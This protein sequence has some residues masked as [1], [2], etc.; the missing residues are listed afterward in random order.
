MNHLIG[1]SNCHQLKPSGVTDNRPGPGFV[2]GNCRQTHYSLSP[3]TRTLLDNP[4]S[5]VKGGRDADRTSAS[6][7]MSQVNVISCHSNENGSIHLKG[8]RPAAAAAANHAAAAASEQALP[9][10]FALGA[11]RR[12]MGRGL[13]ARK[14]EGS[15]GGREGRK[16]AMAKT[17][18]ARPQNLA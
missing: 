9:H 10:S 7:C 11:S 18:L 17:D 6:R 2:I 5:L 12:R 14:M 16:A 4:L 15:E 8:G 3:C 1:Q 13:L